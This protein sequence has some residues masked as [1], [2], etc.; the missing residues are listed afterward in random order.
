MGAEVDIVSVYVPEV[1]VVSIEEEARVLAGGEQ[2]PPGAVDYD[3]VVRKYA[4]TIGN[5]SLRT[6]IVV[7]SLNTLDVTTEVYALA[8]GSRAV[9]D[10]THT[11]PN[12]ITL[13]FDIAPTTNQFRVVVHG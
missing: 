6:I 9:C 11:N 2:G 4:T 3:L 7:H 8:N 10:V 13:V 12:T 5:G 1:S